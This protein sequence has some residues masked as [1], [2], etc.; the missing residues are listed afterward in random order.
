MLDELK[1]VK[2]A[3]ARKDFSPT[4]THFRIE[5]GFIK[6][7]NGAIGLCSPI[8]LDLEIS[9]KAVPFT[10]AIEK[11]KATVEMYIT[12]AGKL[13]IKSGKFKAFIECTDEPYPDIQPEGEVIPM[14][15]DFLPALK[16]ISPFIAE[17]A[18]R[19][20]ARGILFLNGSAFATNNLVLIE[21]H[22]GYSFHTPVNVPK[23]AI[24]ELLRI[25]EEP[26]SMQLTEQS[27]TFNFPNGKW[28]RSALLDLNWP[29]VFKILDRRSLQV[30]PPIGFFEAV[31]DLSPFVD[32][33]GRILMLDTRLTTIDDEENGA[34][35][36]LEGLP[37]SACF[38]FKQLLMLEEIVETI[39]F[40]QYP[41]PC[42]FM[43]ENLRGALIGITIK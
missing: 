8:A 7:Y 35:Y 17:D 25:K 37:E 24:A 21:Y 13:A 31:E 30:K 5:G 23:A 15:G 36:D 12:P 28:L 27:I 38:N 10:K 22:L 1:F 34:S 40:T 11:C 32:E 4:L 16:K 6:G 29:D 20:W 42:I 39:D 9:P 33:A 43:G 26:I 19:P 14:N 18:S 3:V 2:G 41:A